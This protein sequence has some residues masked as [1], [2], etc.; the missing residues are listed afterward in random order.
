MSRIQI[1]YILTVKG[2]I[3]CPQN[4]P[5]SV[6]RE[7]PMPLAISIQFEKAKMLLIVEKV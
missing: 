1:T 6:L 4:V 5:S 2:S 7:T 3:V